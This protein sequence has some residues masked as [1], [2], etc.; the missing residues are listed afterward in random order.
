MNSDSP[1]GSYERRRY[2]N[3]PVVEALCSFA[4]EPGRPWNITIPGIFYEAIRPEY[5]DPPETKEGVEASFEPDAAGGA[6]LSVRRPLKVTYKNENRV[7]T[8]AE[9]YLS[10]HCLVPYEGWESLRA[11]TLSTLNHYRKTAEP[12]SLTAIGLRYVNRV[13]VPESSFRFGDYFAITQGLPDTGFPGAITSFFDRMEYKYTDD[14]TRIVFTWASD[15][16]KEDES[17]A[18]VLDFDLRYPEKVPFE[19]VAARLDDLRKRESLAFESIIGDKL[20]EV[21]DAER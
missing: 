5:P 7:L 2:R 9:N 14:P 15:D 8:V 6:N 17:A 1:A 16:S 3:P 19:D 11:R 21:F 13:V 10:I 18:F 4:F 12:T 20:R